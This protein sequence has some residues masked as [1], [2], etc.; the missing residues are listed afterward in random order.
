[1]PSIEACIQFWYFS[2]TNNKDREYTNKS[3]L[4]FGNGDGGGG[5][6]KAMIERLH[7]L[8]NVEGLPATVKF[9]SPN[10]FYK[11][12]ESTSK[13]LVSW[14]GE[15]YFELHRG[16]FTSHGLIKK[17]NRKSEFLLREVELIAA[18]VISLH[19][20][21]NYENPKAEL[22]RLWKLVL[23]NQF[24]DVLPGSSIGMVYD[25]ATKFYQD[26]EA[27]GKK[28]LEDAIHAFWSGFETGKE[29]TQGMQLFPL[30]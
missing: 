5:P 19:K 6:L 12:L 1:V 21:A 23:L 25:D 15:L 16:T 22:D 24:H 11:E 29:S 2:V 3:L 9:A 8:Q 26:V 18:L 30:H 7:R 17:Y 4:L 14:K 13:D 28:L 10:D 27:S 20:N